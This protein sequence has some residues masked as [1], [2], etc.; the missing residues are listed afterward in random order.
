MSEDSKKLLIIGIVALA[1]IGIGVLIGLSGA[2]EAKASSGR[3]EI[4]PPGYNFGDIDI[5]GGKKSTSFEIVNSGNESVEI[6][7]AITTCMC[8]EAFLDDKI[9]TMHAPTYIGLIEAGERK[10]VTVVF[11]SLAHGPDATGPITREIIFKTNS[12]LTPE[13]TFRFDGNVIK[14]SS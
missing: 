8:T 11:D 10:N 9:I 7:S 6:T 14:K 3:I 13:I 4:R 1:V 2:F 5:F 12:T